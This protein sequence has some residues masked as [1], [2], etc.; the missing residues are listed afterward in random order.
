[1]S[2]ITI[3]AQI[4]MSLTNRITTRTMTRMKLPISSHHQ[5][6][7]KAAVHSKPMVLLLPFYYLLTLYAGFHA[8]V[9]FCS[10]V[11]CVL[12]SSN[13]S[14]PTILYP[15]LTAVEMSTTEYQPSPTTKV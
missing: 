6:D 10:A 14:L 7:F 1:M 12:F 15:I 2:G 5:S 9:C 11:I 4:C 3:I 13:Q 8:C